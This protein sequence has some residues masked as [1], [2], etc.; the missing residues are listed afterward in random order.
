MNRKSQARGK[1]KA[2]ADP[3]ADDDYKIELK[4][5]TIGKQIGAGQFSTVHIGKYFGDY[6]AVKKQ[7]REAEDLETYLVRELAVLRA[8]VDSRLENIVMYMG[9]CNQINLGGAEGHELY[10]I[11]EF[12]QG[13][14]MCDLLCDTSIP[15]GWKFRTQM[16]LQAA[17]AINY[18]HENNF[19]HRDIKSSNFLLGENW[20]CKL[21]DFGMAR[22]VAD[23]STPA[24]M[25][26]CGT[27]E[28]MAPEILF[29]EDYTSG[30]DV[31][32]FGITLLEILKRKKAGDDDFLFRHPRNK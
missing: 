2:P 25:T 23:P 8:L 29:E 14:D 7:V 12:C 6:V 18:L 20:V 27:H 24:T 11:T 4:D 21:T 9:A 31:F 17:M 13:G 22:S 16:A 32:S 10:I 1:V 30:V 19:I 15:L 26:I 3:L 5:V 28:Y